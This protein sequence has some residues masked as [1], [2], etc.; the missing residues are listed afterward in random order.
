MSVVGSATA[1]FLRNCR[2]AI[3]EM[4]IETVNGNVGERV[5]VRGEN[6]GK[7]ENS[8]KTRFRR[9]VTLRQR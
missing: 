2:S 9:L 1:L 5:G 4:M 7:G 6:Q 3:A 8:R